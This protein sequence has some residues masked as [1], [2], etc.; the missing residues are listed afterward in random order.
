MPRNI[1]RMAVVG[2][3][4]AQRALRRKT[5][6]AAPAAVERWNDPLVSAATS[7]VV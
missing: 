7:S 2:R 3:V 4:Q 6:A 1:A 5:R